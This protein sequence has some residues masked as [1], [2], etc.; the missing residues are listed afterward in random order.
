MQQCNTCSS[1]PNNK[2]YNYHMFEPD[3]Y[4]KPTRHAKGI[5]IE[6]LDAV[7]QTSVVT[8]S[9]TEF[10]GSYAKYL[11]CSVPNA[12]YC[13]SLAEQYKAQSQKVNDL[14]PEYNDASQK[15]NTCNNLKNKCAG[16]TSAIEN[17]Q[18]NINEY[19]TKIEDK[20][21]ILNTCD[22]LKEECDKKM[23]R[24]Q[25]KIRQI[26]NLTNQINANKQLYDEN[27]CGT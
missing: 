23:Q 16:I 12:A 22:F 3:E 9:T 24:I 18:K 1:N 15:Y 4:A 21:K 6:G 13:A 27:K 14:E 11:E 25:A 2:T 8:G 7:I 19:D 10:N 17:I 5:I 20:R 26:E